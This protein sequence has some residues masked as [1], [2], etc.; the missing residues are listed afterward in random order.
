MV[1]VKYLI[2]FFMF[3]LALALFSGIYSAS[4]VLGDANHSLREIYGPSENISGWVN[5]SFT[6]ENTNSILSDTLGNSI[7]LF[8]LINKSINSGY[9]YSCNPLGCLTDY[10]AENG[11]TTK[12]FTLN[13]GNST[14]YGLKF[15]GNVI[16][17]NSVNFD[18]QSDAPVS[19]ESQIKV[20]IFDDGEIDYTNENIFSGA[21]CSNLKSY[22]CFDAGASTEE[23]SINTV[24]YCQ[25]IELSESPGFE[26]GAWVQNV[27]GN[28]L[29][30]ME[31]Y[32][33]ESGVPLAS[34]ALPDFSGTGEISCTIDYPLKESEEHFVCISAI[35]GTGNYKIK[36]N[37]NPSPGCGFYGLPPQT[38]NPAAYGIFAEGKNFDAVGTLSVQNSLP[39]GN[40]MGGLVNQYILDNYGSFNCTSGCVVPIRFISGENQNLTISGLSAN[41]EKT[42]GLLSENKFFDLTETPAKINSGFGKFFLNNGGFSVPSTK[43]NYT[44][45]LELNSENVFSEKVSVADVPE[46]DSLTPISTASGFPTEFSVG[47]TSSREVVNYFWDFGDGGIG[48]TTVNKVTHTY[49]SIGEY[50]LLV[51]A[52]DNGSFSSS[53]TFVINVSSPKNLINRTLKSTKENIDRIKTQ[54]LSFDLFTQQSI[55]SAL[56]LDSAESEIERLEELFK[57][58]TNETEY[59]SIVRDLIIIN[60][61]Q[62][63]LESESTS[64]PITFFPDRDDIELGILERITGETFNSSNENGYLNG[65]ILWNQENIDSKIDFKEISGEFKTSVEPIVRI[66]EFEVD[67]KKDIG[68]SYFLIMPKLEGLMFGGGVSS[69]EEGGFVYVDL[70]GVRNGKVSFSTTEDVDFLN[71]PAFISPGFS[72]LSVLDI[73]PPE[74]KEDSRLTIFILSIVLLVVIAGIVYVI[75]RSWYKKKY[76]DYL[77]KNKNDLYNIVNYV[78]NAKK[79]GL[80]GKEIGDHLKKA[81]WSSE[82]I[83]YVMKRYVRK[84]TMMMDIPVSKA[85]GKLNKKN[86]IK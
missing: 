84:G 71:L 80:G 54:I 44:F 28:L 67:E 58:S 70:S 55:D 85:I 24:P 2:T 66:F 17:V 50:D 48:T 5:I 62:S 11:E 79:K 43:G 16:T 73:L 72:R 27:S 14:L 59:S 29:L 63:V 32:D 52:V 12:T 51:T 20:D 49:S 34:C 60:I 7:E 39:S 65:V 10:N 13:S 46:I 23:P 61:P 15:T 74:D 56:G 3:V 8:E 38:N 9:S 36:M 68:G 42:S 37:S 35:G 75:L 78:H 45:N 6:N 33:L 18:L 86:G 69:N 22:G 64:S 21:G 76:E 19:C 30:K 26:V 77:F 81:K 57:N 1:R 4:F 41:Y 47:I 25:K 31:V 83:K 82:Q 40:T 53:R